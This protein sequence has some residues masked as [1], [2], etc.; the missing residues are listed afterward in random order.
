MKYL[1]S[2]KLSNSQ[3][4]HYTDISHSTFSLMLEHIQMQIPSNGSPFEIN[5]IWVK[6]SHNLPNVR[7]NVIR[8]K[9]TM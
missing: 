4:K 9:T 6:H 3:F 2:K 7:L 5:K 8:T 1:D